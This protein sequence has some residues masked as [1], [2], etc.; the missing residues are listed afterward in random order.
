MPRAAIAAGAA[1]HVVA[2]DEIAPLLV[3]LAEAPADR[4]A[5]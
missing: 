3:R 2:L 4:S 1:E 5:A